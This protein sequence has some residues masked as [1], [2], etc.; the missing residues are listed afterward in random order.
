MK[1]PFVIINES[2]RATA[3]AYINTLPIGSVIKTDTDTTRNLE[4]NAA[5]WPILAAFSKQLLWPVNGEMVK[6]SDEEWKDVLTASFKNETARLAMGLDGGVVML[7]KRTSRFS[8][9][10]FS[11]WLE[12]LH[13]VA[14]MRGVVLD[15]RRFNA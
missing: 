4:Q 9:K 10:V 13:A 5:Q 2:V 3:I 12:Y 6:M 7:G 14:A 1:R 11:E 15:D 8:K